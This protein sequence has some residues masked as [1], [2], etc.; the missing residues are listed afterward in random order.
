MSSD[1]LNAMKI[2][3]M[4]M[5]AQGTRLRVIT[6]NIANAD[7]APLKPGLE[8][9][10]R[11]LVT[12]KNVMDKTS[13]IDL[14][15]VESVRDDMKT[16]FIKKYEPG[17]PGADERGYV[18]MPNVNTLIEVMDVREAQR[19]Y[20]ANMGMIEQARAMISRTID[21]LRG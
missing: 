9:Y 19:S 14:V 3:A 13:D 11:Q 21:L 4:G 6:E 1:I 12:F 18:D 5:K 7:T 8:P 20:E 10:R 15:K 16:P 17:H 2:S